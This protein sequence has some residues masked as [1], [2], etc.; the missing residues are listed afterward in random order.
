MQKQQKKTVFVNERE[1]R[2]NGKIAAT[3]VV[4][5]FQRNLHDP[6]KHSKKSLCIFGGAGISGCSSCSCYPVIP[7]L[8]L[9]PSTRLGFILIAPLASLASLAR[10]LRSPCQFESIFARLVQLGALREAKIVEKTL[11]K[12]LK[13]LLY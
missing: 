7:P 4:H 1:A 5:A 12:H 9:L 11:K 8:H 2:F 10:S 13:N 6:W 3:R